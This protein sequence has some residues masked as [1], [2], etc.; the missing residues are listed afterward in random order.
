MGRAAAAVLILILA[1]STSEALETVVV[2]APSTVPIKLRLTRLGKLLLR[3]RPQQRIPVRLVL[4]SVPRSRT[5]TVQGFVNCVELTMDVPPECASA[6][7]P[8]GVDT[9]V[10]STYLPVTRPRKRIVGQSLASE[11]AVSLPLTALGARLCAKLKHLPVHL[12][13]RSEG[14][15]SETSQTTLECTT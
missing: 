8:A 5:V 11:T 4:R 7:A 12:F 2:R 10:T 6:V 1:M 3:N 15:A 9:H 14:E 13:A